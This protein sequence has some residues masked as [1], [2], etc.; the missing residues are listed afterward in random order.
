MVNPWVKVGGNKRVL[1]NGTV[2]GL[3]AAQKVP[4]TAVVYFSKPA[5]GIEWS[6]GYDNYY[7]ASWAAQTGNGPES[8]ASSSVE[9][10]SPDSTP[11]TGTGTG[12]NTNATD[13]V[14][15]P[16]GL[17]WD[18]RATGPNSKDEA[19]IKLDAK[20]N[21]DGRIAVTARVTLDGGAGDN[22]YMVNPWVKMGSTKRLIYSGRIGGLGATQKVPYTKV[23]YFTKPSANVSWSVGYENY[24]DG[25][26]VAQTGKGQ[27]YSNSGVVAVSS[28][29]S[30][31]TDTGGSTTSSNPGSTDS[32]SAAGLSAGRIAWDSRTTA[33]NSKDEA[34]ITVDAKDNGDGRILITARVNLDGGA[35]DDDY[36][37][38]PWVQ[39]GSKKLVI[40]NG[41]IGGKGASQKV[42][43]T[44]QLY[45]QKPASNQQW[46]V[47]YDKY[48]DA[49]WPGQTGAGAESSYKSTLVVSASSPIA[50]STST[51]TAPPT[52]A[53][54]ASSQPV[55][56]SWDSR[57][58][59]PNTKDEAL[60]SIN[61]RETSDGRVVVTSTINL[62][63][64]IGD[65]D[66][67]VNPWVQLGSQRQL[68][69]KGSVGG[70]GAS[71]KIPY[72]KVI[73]FNKPAAG[74][75]WSIGYDNYFDANW[76]AQTGKGSESSG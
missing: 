53:P 40:Y 19:I 21:G 46:W 24:Y 22:D 38:N 18:S 48:Y 23:I 37:V 36:I 52:T 59:G 62:D 44:K 29:G 69:Y 20:D 74:A 42:P 68:L 14:V 27:E 56:L 25:S 17:S 15:S 8:S 41:S 16:V 76:P 12:T 60:I 45:L 4:F 50:G 10:E 75:K 5:G 55:V 66:Y 6:L 32:G 47:G 67:I 61:A 3:G 58:G 28:S 43:Y 49:S 70:R 54:V 7:D 13:T 65:D 9:L 72:T 11:G 35:T 39:V 30:S 2:G 31:N 26:W 34:L 51:N 1:Y 63:G 57:S 73:Y 71:Q 64:G 33:P